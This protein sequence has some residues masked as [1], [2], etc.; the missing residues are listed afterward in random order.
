MGEDIEDSLFSRL[1]VGALLTLAL[2]FLRFG[3]FLGSGLLA[4]KGP[5][6]RHDI[7]LSYFLDLE[8]LRFLE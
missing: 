5:C 2:R 7:H 6:F 8:E 1:A 4:K 3:L